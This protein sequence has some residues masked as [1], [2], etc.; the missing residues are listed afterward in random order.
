MKRTP[1]YNQITSYNEDESEWVLGVN[2]N[3]N[4]IGLY[5]EQ[6]PN[7]KFK[8]NK[9]RNNYSQILNIKRMAVE[10]NGDFFTEFSSRFK[11]RWIINI[12]TNNNIQ[13]YIDII[14]ESKELYPSL[15]LT[16]NYCKTYVY[17]WSYEE[18]RYVVDSKC[19]E[20]NYFS[21]PLTDEMI[22]N[23]ELRGC[24]KIE[25]Y[26]LENIYNQ[27]EEIIVLREEN[28]ALKQRLA[29]IEKFIDGLI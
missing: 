25:Q 23:P 15:S 16:D 22:D 5:T 10:L 17:N 2:E 29:R 13:P 8:F 24:N 21:I 27:G 14:M 20:Y 12:T 9:H 7:G 4:S 18:N 3:K 19:L 26:L 1:G 6:D 11:N 28:E